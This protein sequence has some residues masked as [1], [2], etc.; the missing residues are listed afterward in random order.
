M[1]SPIIAQLLA[2]NV[3][4]SVGANFVV[5]EWKDAGG[6][7]GP[8]RWIAPL[9]LHHNDDEA[10]Y[11]LEGTLCVRVGKDIVEAQAGSAVFVPRGKAHTYWNPGPGLVRYLLVMTSNI[12]ALI[13]DIHAMTER[14]PAALRAVFEKHDSE[15]V[16]E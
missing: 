13:Q 1:S 3:I 6:P 8:P 7:P 15:L 16:N 11:V 4:G 5:A 14:S 10:W 12:Y 9:H 2:G